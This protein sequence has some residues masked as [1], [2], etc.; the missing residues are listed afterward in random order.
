MPRVGPFSTKATS[1][2]ASLEL[3]DVPDPKVTWGNSG[4]PV[5]GW[6]EYRISSDYLSPTASWELQFVA[7]LAPQ[8]GQVQSDMARLMREIQNGSR[9]GL[10]INGNLVLT[11]Y[12]DQVHI[13]SSRGSGTNLLVRGRDALSVACDAC[14]DPHF[15]FPE[16]QS[17][18]AFL[19]AL[20]SPLG[21]KTFYVSD[22]LNRQKM[23]GSVSTFALDAHD[24]VVE[25]QL[26]TPI[27]SKFKPQ[28]NEGVY[29]FAERIGKRFGFYVR[30]GV[31]GQSLFIGSPDYK[32]EPVGT[33]VHTLDGKRS[34]ILSSGVTWDWSKQPSVIIGS[35][36][37]R[38]SHGDPFPPYTIKSLMVN[39]LLTDSDQLPVIRK[40]KEQYKH[41]VQ[42]P[43][44]DYITRPSR[45]V[46][47]TKFTKPI[48]VVDDESATQEHLNNYVRRM[49]ADYQAKFLVAEYVV[50]GH[51][52][53][54]KIWVP[55]SM[56]TV[57]DEVSGINQVM[58][59]KAVEYAKSRGGGTTTKLTLL[60][61]FVLE[62]IPE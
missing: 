57:Q 22:K 38:G 47:I 60:L 18:K 7:S 27:N 14:V 33:L 8:N 39:E 54:K 46:E 2:E 4:K 37:G 61:P 40:L 19:E 25:K 51:S 35:A 44:R 16:G 28:N 31:D 32:Q 5:K 1:D 55:N 62:L 52:Q 56:V 45:V 43:R 58:W 30:A 10:R 42:I 24:K 15:E 29:E 23:S 34:N 50:P 21:F 3:L 26:T 17:V 13:D 41:A 48:W 6:T 9:I 36:T 11:G 20:M 53:K 49:M 59:I 12:V